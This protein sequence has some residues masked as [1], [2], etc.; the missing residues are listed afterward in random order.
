[1]ASSP[2]LNTDGPVGVQI[3]LDGANMADSIMMQSARITRAVN[4][5]PDARFTILSNSPQV[6]D[7][8][9]LDS[10]DFALGTEV[11]IG[12]FYGDGAEQVLFKG[13]I[14]ATRVRMNSGVGMMLELTCRDKALKLTEVRSTLNYADMT[15]SDVME[16][17]IGDAGLSSDVTATQ[18]VSPLHMRIGTSDWDFL[19]LLA[20][21]NGYV[22]TVDDATLTAAA[23]DASTEPVLTVTYGIDIMELDVSIDA[24]RM[25]ASAQTSAWS[26]QEQEVVSDAFAEIPSD[27]LGNTIPSDIAAALGDRAQDT[28]TARDISQ[29]DLASLSKAR[30]KRAALGAMRGTIQFQGCGAVKPTDMIEIAASG[31]RFSGNGFV[32]GV[33]HTIEA[34]SWTTQVR[35]GLPQDWTSDTF[36]LAAPAAGALVT[37]IHGL[38]IG[39]VLSLVGDPEGSQR[40]QVSLPMIG[41]PAAEV[42][43][44]FASPY[45]SGAVGIQFLPE[46]GDEVLVA[47]LN[48]DPNAPVI[49]GSLHNQKALRPLEADEENTIK[50]IVTRENLSVSFDDDKKIITVETPGGHI[51]TLDDDASAFS[52]EDMNGNKIVMDSSGIALTSDKDI[53]LTATGNVNVEATGDANVKGM[54]VN[55]EGQ[56]GFTGKGGASAELSAGG[57]TKV[58]GAMVMIN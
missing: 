16:Q 39:K 40:I 23:P 41:D 8:D 44:R 58:E 6:E 5:I 35:L 7:F 2:E 24:Q 47:F 56:T 3:K 1:M 38:Q 22:L 14:L 20:D 13:I 55:C 9:A 4:R 21:L 15:D 45:A 25:I 37:P 46:Q 33:E 18:A 11:E 31:D 32:S 29:A 54:N 19:R 26:E 51:L 34:G 57:Q 27:M 10:E 52:M 49:V 17:I 30:L 28:S 48:A 50:T 36:G 12:A 53:S 43:A 42:W